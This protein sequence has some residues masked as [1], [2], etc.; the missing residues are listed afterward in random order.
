VREDGLVW[1]SP[2]GWVQATHPLGSDERWWPLLLPVAA[3]VLL[4]VVAFAMT[5]H[6]DVGAGLVAQRAGSPTASGLLAGPV[7]LA[8]RLQRGAV[9]G[10]AAGLL[11]LAL[12][13]GSL[14]R[15]VAEMTRDNPTL[16]DYLQATGQ[17]S[18]TDAYFSTM[19]LILALLA[20]AFALSS[21]LRLRA[22]E[23]ADRLEVLLA[24]GLS[25]TRWLLASLVVTLGGTL[26]LLVV[27][28]LG[29]GVAHGLV[30]S[31]AGQPLRMA[32]LMLVYAPA[33]L[34]V[35]ALAVLLVGWLP[36]AVAVAW[37]ALAVCF[38]IGWLGGLLDPPHWVEELSPF[39]HTPSV[40]VEAVTLAA[41][42]LVTL[43]VVL[44]VGAGVLGFRRRDIG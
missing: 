41:P 24:T 13:V 4:V 19:L 3:A 21:A 32:G 20:A 9:L 37:A 25:R 14:S 2:V 36:R 16:S 8:W 17:G 29:V 26:L 18:P 5:D 7:G 38:L 33:A 43:S 22:E 11:A 44:L 27:S 42:S 30:T 28:G 35:A 10:W 6:R 34:S 39:W 23:S 12:A 15:E 31:D 40:P 1:L